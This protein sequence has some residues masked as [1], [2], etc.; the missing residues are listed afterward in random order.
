MKSLIKYFCSDYWRLRS[1]LKDIKKAKLIFERGDCSSMCTA[2]AWVD[3]HRYCKEGRVSTVS[4]YIPEFNPKN[5]GVKRIT[6]D[7]FWWE[8][9]DKDSRINA[10]NKLI[11]IYENKIREF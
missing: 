9:K 8:R 4:D 1:I 5:L 2:F 7:G 3:Y 10:F 6:K 11:S